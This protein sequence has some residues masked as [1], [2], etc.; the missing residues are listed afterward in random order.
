MQGRLHYEDLSQAR[1]L[2]YLC[3]SEKEVARMQATLKAGLADTLL[4]QLSAT[5]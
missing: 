5:C 2:G 1:R 3:F 4:A